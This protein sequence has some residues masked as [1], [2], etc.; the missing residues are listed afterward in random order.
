MIERDVL[1]KI[2]EAGG[3]APSIDNCQPWLFRVSGDSIHIL[4]D[5]ARAEF[6][7]DY[8]HTG[9]YVTIGAVIENIVVAAEYFGLNPSVTPF[10]A[11][12]DSP[13]A[14]ISFSRAGSQASNPLY[15]YIKERCTNRK[16]YSRAALSEKHLREIAGIPRPKG[17]VLH[18]IQD[19]KAIRKVARLAA[20]V[21]RTS[22]E[23][24]F[25][26]QGLFKWIR[27]SE[28]QALR[29]G[30][31]LPV[32]ALD[33]NIMNRASLR[34]MSHWPLTDFL[35]NFGLSYV[36]GK[37]NSRLLLQASAIGFIVMESSTR[38]DYLEGGRF[39]ER[40][41]LKA[42]SLGLSLQ[43]FGGT[44]FLLTR[45]LRAKESG[46]SESQRERLFS[47]YEK[48]KGMFSLDEKNGFIMLFRVGYCGEPSVRAPRRPLSEIIL[49]S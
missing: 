10:P 2:V 12:K 35:N 47:V 9:S 20:S 45:L 32:G 6:F 1:E 13:A 16:A 28:E 21:D 49:K 7:G 39:F 17:A 3:R 15:P 27:W 42:A 23:H 34:M 14:K 44:A 22:F 24:K 38:E 37:V 40:I 11:E 8:N 4:L 46:Y 19:R 30:D 36:V 33:L 26:H 43:P 25:L 29:S 48:L 18:L 5:E 41:W 31:G